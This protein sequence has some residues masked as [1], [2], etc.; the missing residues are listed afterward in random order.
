MEAVCFP[1]QSPLVL[2]Y[3][4]K[5]KLALLESPLR[6]VLFFRLV[7]LRELLYC[8]LL[9]ESYGEIAL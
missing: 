4:V 1:L 6:Y 2:V 8:T 5:I 9:Y 7:I 3:T